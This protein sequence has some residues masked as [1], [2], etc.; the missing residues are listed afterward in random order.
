MAIKENELLDIKHK[1]KAAIEAQSKFL[2]EAETDFNFYL[3]GDNQ[4]DEATLSKLRAA[5]RPVL[6]INIVKRIIDIITGL[7]KSN[8]YEWKYLPTEETDIELTEILNQISKHIED[9]NDFE[10]LESQVF[11]ILMKI[12][13]TV[14]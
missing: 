13:L 14:K 12:P 10:F 2:E 1:R 11:R 3:G 7:Q 8:R 5:K 4:W 6:S 9:N